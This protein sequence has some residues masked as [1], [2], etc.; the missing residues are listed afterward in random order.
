[1]DL[2]FLD[3]LEIPDLFHV[4]TVIVGILYRRFVQS[5]ITLRRVAGDVEA[6]V[7]LDQQHFPDYQLICQHFIVT[8]RAE[9]EQQ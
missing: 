4:I 6:G 8:K 3:D 5:G 9:S 1:M 2:Q 7:P